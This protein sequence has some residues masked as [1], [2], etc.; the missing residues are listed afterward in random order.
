M[1][2]LDPKINT[3]QCHKTEE[4]TFYKHILQYTKQ[5]YHITYHL[6]LIK[7]TQIKLCTYSPK[8]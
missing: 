8:N 6:P 7:Y 1:L 3:Y 2:M 4:T 5:N